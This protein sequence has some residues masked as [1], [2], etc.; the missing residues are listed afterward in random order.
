MSESYHNSNLHHQ[1]QIIN[2]EAMTELGAALAK[3]IKLGTIVYLAG[4]L[5]AGKTTLVRGFLRAFGHH[6]AVKSPTFTVVEPYSLDNNMFYNYNKLEVNLK[7][8]S[9]NELLTDFI[10]VYHFDLY[11]LEDPEELEYIGIRDYLDGQAIALIE[12]PEKGEGVLPGADLIIKIVHQNKGREIELLP[13][14]ENGSL[15]V[16]RLIANTEN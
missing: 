1:R 11:R 9:D 15:I 4:D 12:W 13:Q 16:S 14:S 5:G 6:G 2:E 7:L 8:K 10:K 3:W